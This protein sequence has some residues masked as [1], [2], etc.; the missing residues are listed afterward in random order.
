M[1]DLVDFLVANGGLTEPV[2]REEF[3]LLG[4]PAVTVRGPI[5]GGQYVLST[6]TII[7]GMIVAVSV[8][9]TDEAQVT[10][11]ELTFIAM[12]Q[13]LQ[14]GKSQLISPNSEQSSL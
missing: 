6:Q 2:Q 4:Q 12:L 3:I 14:A 1:S 9:G 7:D 10:A 5:T 13:T 8:V 11:F